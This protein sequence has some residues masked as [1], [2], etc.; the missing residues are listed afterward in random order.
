MSSS[1][2]FPDDAPYGA[3]NQEAARALASSEEVRPLAWRVQWAAVGWSN[4]VGHACFAAGA[5]AE[6][7]CSVDKETGEVKKPT[8]QGVYKAIRAAVAAGVISEES[9][10]RCLVLPR[11]LWQKGGKGNSSCSEHDVGVV[12]AT[13]TGGIGKRSAEA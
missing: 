5:L 4:R 6:I 9:R 7:L 12:G 10:A 13:W 8:P 2:R 3:V 11:A 1:I